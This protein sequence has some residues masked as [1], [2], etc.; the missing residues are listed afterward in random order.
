[1][2]VPDNLIVRNKTL[3]IISIAVVTSNLSH[4]DGLELSKLELSNMSVTM[5][6]VALVV[7]PI[8]GLLAACLFSL[9][10]YSSVPIYDYLSGKGQYNTYSS[11]KKV[12]LEE[13]IPFSLFLIVTSIVN[14]ILYIAE[15]MTI[16]DLLT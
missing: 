14:V 11:K 5:L 12:G 7:M 2:I 9:F 4:F 3:I 10:L 16:Y 13:T 6:L 1:M 8:G 15:K